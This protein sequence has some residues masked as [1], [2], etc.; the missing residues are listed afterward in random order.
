M[1]VGYGQGGL[2]ALLCTKPLVLELACRARIVS[3]P[4][5]V[6][7]RRTWPGV[8]LVA[9]I[10]PQATKQGL[11]FEPVLQAIPELVLPQPQGILRWVLESPAPPGAEGSA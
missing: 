10:N 11:N 3:A 4:E 7:I 5:M 1:I 8:V 2:I 9:G 6:A